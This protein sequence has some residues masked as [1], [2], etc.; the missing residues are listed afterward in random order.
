MSSLHPHT[1]LLTALDPRGLSVRSV[2]YHRI[3]WQDE[4]QARFHRHVLSSSGFLLQQWDPRLHALHET[5]AD[6]QPN[7]AYRYSL[8]G[9]V[10][11]TRSVDAGWQ[12]LL[13]GGNGQMLRAWDG[14]GS[15]QRYEYDHLLRSTA[16]FEQAADEPGERCV[17]RL[18]YAAMTPEHARLNGCGRLIRHDD[19]CGTLFFGH[20]TLLGEVGAQTRRFVQHPQAIDWAEPQHVR[21]A[22]LEAEGYTSKWHY[23]ALGGLLEQIDAKGNRQHSQYTIGAELLS[24]A[25]VFKSGKRHGLLTQRRYNAKGQVVFEQLGNGVVTQ[26]TYAPATDRLQRLTTHRPGHAGAPLQD[27]AYTYDRVGNVLSIHDAAQPTTWANNAQVEAT[28]TYAYDTLYQLI[29]A[30]GRENA[31]MGRA[32]AAALVL[33]GATDGNVMRNYTRFYHYD[34][35]ANLTHMQH[36]PSSGQ[37]YTQPMQVAAQSNQSLQAGVGAGFDQ[38]GNQ[39]SLVRGQVMSWNVRNQ[40]TSVTQVMRE[41]GNHDVETYGY[42]A[43]GQR[44]IKRRLSQG[45]RLTQIDEVRYLPGLE[46]HRHQAGD[47]VLQVLSV[48]LGLTQIRALKW[49]QGLPTGI[50]DEQLRFGLSNHV[51]S[52][53]LELDQQAELLSQEGYYPYGATAWWSAKSVVHATY[54]TLR[55]SGKERD[56]TGLY[57]YGFRYYAPW[58]R[59]WISADRAGDVD[60]LNLYAMVK[61]NPVRFRDSDGRVVEEFEDYSANSPSARVAGYPATGSMLDRM[62][63]DDEAARRQQAVMQALTHNLS[64]EHTIHSTYI[65][66]GIPNRFRFKNEYLPG[67]WKF[68]EN[69]RAPGSSFYATDVT[70]H[71][72]ERV[73]K[74]NLFFG[75]LPKLIVRW[76]VINPH[77]LRATDQ[78]PSGS[79]AMR[80]SFL[81]SEGTGRSTQRILDAFGLRATRV[82]RRE[83]RD[84]RIGFDIDVITIAVEP[85]PASQSYER[86]YQEVERDQRRATRPLLSRAMHSVF[87]AFNRAVSAVARRL[88]AQRAWRANAATR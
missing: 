81:A 46:L 47:E 78:L 20:Y 11:H 77:A 49:E 65:A 22:Q 14:R 31:H 71:Q 4:P 68:M 7:T 29:E 63:G 60:G 54:K 39:L 50:A 69:F 72:Y 37:G 15:Q 34:A 40:L 57:Y 3:R 43:A 64:G 83:V 74:K 23:D 35:G 58:L 36:V 25:L 66:P 88:Q 73:S 84:L 67:R 33:S 21:D 75:V 76:D 53:T 28:N 6:V 1:P 42:D 70:R 10:V 52:T 17:E 24:V 41:E 62:S 27:L 82:E 30:R 85:L 59:R 12:R 86:L 48:A 32:A 5:D 80:D 13:L 9:R 8:S 19:P 2:A 45:Q 44:V 38:N 51:G 61:N 87:R 55:F 26:A 16:M 79:D 18:Y 56:A